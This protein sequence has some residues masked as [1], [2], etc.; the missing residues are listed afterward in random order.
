MMTFAFQADPLYEHCMTFDVSR[1]H[2]EA[3]GIKHP[4]IRTAKCDREMWKEIT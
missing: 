3:R 1:A 4:R 2:D